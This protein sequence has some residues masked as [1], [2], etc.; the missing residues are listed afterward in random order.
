ML[1]EQNVETQLIYKNYDKAIQLLVE[2][3]KAD[4]KTL[5]NSY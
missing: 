1:E 4:D 5:I 2:D 3:R